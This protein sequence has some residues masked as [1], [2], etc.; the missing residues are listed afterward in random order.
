MRPYPSNLFKEI[1]DIYILVVIKQNLFELDIA[2]PPYY[3]R[4]E[5][6]SLNETKFSNFIVFFKLSGRRLKIEIREKD[7]LHGYITKI[8]IF[9][10]VRL[11]RRKSKE[12]FIL[13][14]FHF[15]LNFFSL[16]F[17][18]FYFSYFFRSHSAVL[19]CF[20]FGVN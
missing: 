14:R 2:C 5:Q 11:A 3:H 9:V 15:S 16:S 7:A 6:M 12:Y 8:V 20:M 13:F 19:K 17:L 1:L 4:I 18:L 10:T